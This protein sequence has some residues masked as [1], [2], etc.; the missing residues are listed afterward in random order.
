MAVYSAP[1]D[2]LARYMWSWGPSG[3]RGKGMNRD[4]T[5]EKMSEALRGK[6]QKGDREGKR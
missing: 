4:S 6:E 5:T 1:S 3:R 2:L